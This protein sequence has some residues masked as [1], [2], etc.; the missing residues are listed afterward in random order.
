MGISPG[1]G[2]HREVMPKAMAVLFALTHIAAGAGIHE[3]HELAVVGIDHHDQAP[4]AQ[5]QGGEMGCIAKVVPGRDHS[6]HYCALG[7][8]EGSSEQLAVRL[9]QCES[10]AQSR[11]SK[12]HACTDRA[13]FSESCC[14]SVA[15]DIS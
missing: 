13:M 6:R 4:C 9:S 10:T 2:A 5:G 7:K 15:D 12:S 1:S 11:V 8:D 3:I 14:L